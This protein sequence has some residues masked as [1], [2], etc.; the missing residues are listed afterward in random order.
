MGVLCR[1]LQTMT[2]ADSFHALSELSRRHQLRNLGQRLGVVWG[3]RRG[4]LNS[5]E[6]V[7]L[8]QCR[9][10]L[11]FCCGARSLV[12]AALRRWLR[13]TRLVSGI[14]ISQRMA[15]WERVIAPEAGGAIVD[16]LECIPL[17]GSFSAS[18]SRIQPWLAVVY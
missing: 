15:L 8:G 12:R 14:N 10:C 2:L 1:C 9:F 18:S 7:S 11:V 16:D 13:L 4:H 17:Y 6:L 3:R 5:F